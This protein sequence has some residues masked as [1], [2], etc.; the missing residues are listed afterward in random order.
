MKEKQPNIQKIFIESFS[1]KGDGIGYL[2]T[3]PPCRVEVPHLLIGDTAYVDVRK[4]RRSFCKGRLT[5]IVE[6]S[7]SRTEPKCPH[8]RICGGC[9]WQEMLYEKQIE[10]KQ[11]ILDKIFE[12]VASKEISFGKILPAKDPFYYR[13][14][15]EF[16]FSENKAGTKFLGLMIARAQ[17]YVFSVE[18]CALGGIWFSQVLQS[19]RLWWENSL[20]KA[21]HHFSN[22]GTLRSL[23]LRE[24][25]YTQQK[26]VILAVSG[27]EAFLLTQEQKNSFIETVKKNF[28]KEEQA[29]LSIYLR[30][31]KI[32]KNH[33]TEFIEEHLF[34]LTHIQEILHIADSL[35]TFTISPSSFFQPNTLQAERLYSLALEMGNVNKSMRVFD[36]Y[37]GTG[38][39]GMIF[40]SFVKEVIGIELNDQAVSDAKKNLQ[41]NNIKNFTL[42]SGDVGKVLAKLRLEK[43]F[44]VP[45]LVIVDPPR[46]GL[47]EMA[48]EEI[49][50]LLP[51]K[52]LYVSCNPLTQI[53]DIK[54]LLLSG[55][56]LK[57]LQA[58]DQF[59]HTIHIENMA[60]LE[61]A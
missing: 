59:P 61:R 45:D 9:L 2:E 33:P 5:E 50:N 26:M 12:E 22:Q 40:S 57:K 48:L 42:H 14:K 31:Q 55:Y 51:Q 58:V 56:K 54:N 39:F 30:I 34:G 16:S 27:D 41:L 53:R 3:T 32:A 47:D 38:I 24:A 10:Q 11:K 25:K 21:Y 60:L 6:P 44:S 29:S 1:S 19:V 17:N 15:M 49:K 52:I 36:L 23:T 20:I 43:D 7:S 8:T 18:K 13:N 28:S 4:K 35:F 46:S 37:C